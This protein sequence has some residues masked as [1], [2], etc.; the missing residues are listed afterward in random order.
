MPPGDEQPLG[1]VDV[2]VGMSERLQWWHAIEGKRFAELNRK[3][4]LFVLLVSRN[5][6]QQ[7]PV[8]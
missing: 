2:C 6:R 8:E 3:R 4:H 5:S 1:A 7:R